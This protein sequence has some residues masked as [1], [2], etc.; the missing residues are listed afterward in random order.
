MTANAMDSD[1]EACL[2]AGMDD[3]V[4]KPFKSAQLYAAL[5]RWLPVAEA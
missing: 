3:Y 5:A 2:D 4:P 1:R